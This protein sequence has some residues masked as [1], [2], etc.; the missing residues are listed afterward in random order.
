VKLDGYNFAFIGNLKQ[1]VAERS[2]PV[3]IDAAIFSDVVGEVKLN[4]LG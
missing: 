3:E 2:K 1:P 4:S